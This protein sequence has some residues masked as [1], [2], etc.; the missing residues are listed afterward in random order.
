MKPIHDTNEYQA[1]H[2]CNAINCNWLWRLVESYPEPTYEILCMHCIR[3]QDAT[4]LL[5]NV[6]MQACAIVRG[7]AVA[8]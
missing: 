7:S 5:D 4:F 1:C 8:R 6:I 3:Q 2:H